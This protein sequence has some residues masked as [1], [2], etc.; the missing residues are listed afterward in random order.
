VRNTCTYYTALNMCT[1]TLNEHI[2]AMLTLYSASTREVHVCKVTASHTLTSASVRA[3]SDM[4]VIHVL[5][6]Q[7]Y[8]TRVLR[9]ACNQEHLA[10][11]TV[12]R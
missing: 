1:C 8:E 3:V 6:C 11:V 4:L 10:V 5:C 7:Q 12:Q 2:H 9:D